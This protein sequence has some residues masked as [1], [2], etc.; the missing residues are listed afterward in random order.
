MKCCCCCCRQSC[1]AHCTSSSS[2]SPS[3]VYISFKNFLF[4]LSICIQTLSAVVCC[5]SCNAPTT[6]NKLERCKGKERI[7]NYWHISN[8]DTSKD[9]FSLWPPTSWLH[10]MS[11]D[12][13]CVLPYN[14]SGCW[15][16]MHRTRLNDDQS[17]CAN[18]WA[19]CNPRQQEKQQVI[20]TA[21]WDQCCIVLRPLDCDDCDRY[22]DD[23][24]LI[25]LLQ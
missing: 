25:L 21:A 1:L 19:A 22:N 3:D 8:I 13:Q 18:V 17:F 20:I 2:P 24:L 7:V 4:L 10:S 5:C 6:G 12:N 23:N 14:W 15:R 9:F 16:Q 11:Y